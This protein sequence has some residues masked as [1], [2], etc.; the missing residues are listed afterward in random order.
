MLKIL[1]S[2]GK[3]G[4]SFTNSSFKNGNL[5]LALDGGGHVV[6]SGVNT[7]DTFNINGTTYKISG[8]KLK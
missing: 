1:K 7:S 8:G 5:T 4:G 6:F 3:D 2:N